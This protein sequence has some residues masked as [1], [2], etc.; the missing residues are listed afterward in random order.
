MYSFVTFDMYIN[1]TA[2]PSHGC[3]VE[4]GVEIHGS[5]WRLSVSDYV[6]F[7]CH[8]SYSVNVVPIFF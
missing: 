3:L 5:H 6:S 8:L 2:V 7:L 4:Y 1:E